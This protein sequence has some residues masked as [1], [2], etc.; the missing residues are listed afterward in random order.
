MILMPDND[1]VK[2]L[3][4]DALRKLGEKEANRSRAT[5]G[6]LGRMAKE[7]VKHTIFDDPGLLELLGQ[8]KDL[9]EQQEDE[10]YSGQGYTLGEGGEW[11]D[12]NWGI[13]AGELAGNWVGS[14]SD[15]DY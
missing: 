12:S 5:G 7:G 10:H 14:D 13:Q 2:T 6:V 15:A 8:T 11:E 3:R 9:A 4:T 1:A